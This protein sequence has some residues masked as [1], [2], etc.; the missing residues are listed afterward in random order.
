MPLQI[1]MPKVVHYAEAVQS[2][3]TK[4]AFVKVEEDV[5]Q[6][7]HTPTKCRDFLL[8]TLV[9]NAKEVKPTSIYGWSYDDYCEELAIFNIKDPK[10]LSEVHK[11]EQEFGMTLTELVP[12]ET[13]GTFYIKHDPEWRKNT[14]MLSFYTLILRA[15]LT[16]KQTPD[17]LA[18]SLA[19]DGVFGTMDDILKVV[20][21]ARE[22]T[23][24]CL[25][26]QTRDKYDVHNTSG[27]CSYFVRVANA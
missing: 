20:R 21:K 2:C 25:A 11:I 6:V 13:K 15:F 26:P 17:A 14:V 1:S 24:V 16:R 22:E 23:K 10:N 9:W 5:M 7:L 12:T 27:V 18:A 19:S 3:S 4:F 8:D